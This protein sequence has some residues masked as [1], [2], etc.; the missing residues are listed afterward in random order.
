MNRENIESICQL[1][2][3]QESLILEKPS[4]IEPGRYC[5]Q[6]S[7][8]LVGKLDLTAI[9]DA[10]RNIVRRHQALR[11]ALALNRLEHP[12]QIVFKDVAL[13]VSH[14]DWRDVSAEALTQRLIDYL[15][16]D[17]EAGFNP[18]EAPLFRLS[19]IRVSD[20]EYRFVWTCNKL[21][22]DAV[23]AARVISEAFALYEASQ[24]GKQAVLPASGSYA[25]Y[26]AALNDRDQTAIEQFWRR[27]LDYSVA[28]GGL[29]FEGASNRPSGEQR[30]H[31]V[32]QVQLSEVETETVN[33]FLNRHEISVSALSRAAWA[34]T[35]SCYTNRDHAVFGAGVVALSEPGGDSM[36]AGPL[37]NILPF[38]TK[39]VPSAPLLTWLNEIQELGSRLQAHSEVSSRQL[40]EWHGVPPD[41]KLFD[42]G[43]FCDH[44]FLN[45]PRFAS[46]SFASVELWESAC[47][48]LAVS[49]S[50]T[51]LITL[52][53]TYETERFSDGRIESMLSA[54]R[55]AFQAIASEAPRLIA[56]VPLAPDEVLQRM[57]VE[58]NAG[59]LDYDKSILVNALF[60]AQ[61]QRLPMSLALDC[62]GNQ[63]SFQELNERANQLARYLAALGVGRED[64]VGIYIERSV[65]MVVG[66]L[67]IIKSGA[68]FVPLATS[69]PVERLAYMMESSRIAVLLTRE[70]L[71][72][73]LP[74]HWLQ[75]VCLD[76]DWP[77]IEQERDEDLRAA[78]EPDDVAY[79]MYTSGS[80]GRPKGVAVTHAGLLNLIHWHIR[81]FALASDDHATQIASIG[82]DASVW[83]IWP[84]LAAGATLHIVD[85]DLRA[86]PLDLM[87]WVVSSCVTVSF[88]PTPIAECILELDWPASTSLRILLVGGDRLRDYPRP[89]LP[90]RLV[91]NYGPTENTVVATSGVVLSDSHCSATPSIGRPISNTQVYLLDRHL[92]PVPMGMAGELC[93]AGESLAREYLGQP[94]LTAER[95]IPDPFGARPGARLYATGD[96]A[97]Y[98]SDGSIDFLGRRDHQVKIRGVRIELG[99]IEAVLASHPAVK[100]AVVVLREDAHEEKRLIAYIVP[101]GQPP[102]SSELQGY[103]YERLTDAMIPALFVMLNELPLTANGKLDRKALPAPDQRVERRIK[104]EAPKNEIEK[105]IVDVWKAVLKIDD[106]GIND[107]FFELG[108]DSILSIQIVAQANQS[109]LRITAKQLFEKKTIAE[110]AQVATLVAQA[111]RDQA[112]VSGAAPLT[113]IQEWFL[114]QGIAEVNRYN[115][116]VMLEVKEEID[117]KAMKR[118]MDAIMK[119]HDGLRLRFEKEE[120]QWRSRIEEEEKNE[121][122]VHIDLRET[123]KERQK[124]EIEAWANELQGSLRLKEGPILRAASFEL[125]EGRGRRLYMVAHHLGV[126]GVSWRILLEDLQRAYEQARRGEELELGAKTTSYKEWAKTLIEYGQSEGVRKEEVYWE[127]EVRRDEGGIKCDKEGGR[128]EVGSE[129]SVYVRMG[130]EETR[131]LLQDC[132][133][134]YRSQINELLLS[135]LA[136]SYE[137]WTGQEALKIEMEGHGREEVVEGVDVT[138]TVGWFT[139]VYPVVLESKRGE[140]AVETIKRVKEKL[141]SIPNKGIGYG[142]LRKRL[143][144]AGAPSSGAIAD[145]AFNYFGQFDQAVAGTSLFGL[146]QELCG[147]ACS[148]DAKR[149]HLIDITSLVAAGGLEINWIYSRNRF[150]RESIERFAR[151]YEEELLGIIERSKVDAISAFTASDF[152]LAQLSQTQVDEIAGGY[153]D[154]EDIYP[155]S[156]LQEGVLFHTLY[157]SGKGAY[158]EQLGCAMKGDINVEALKRAWQEEAQ[159]HAIWRTAFVWKGLGRPVQVVRRSV[160]LDWQEEDWRGLSNA[161]QRE[162]LREYFRK[163]RESGF[164]VDEAPLLKL[165]LIRLADDQYE[166]LWTHHHLLLDG[167]SASIVIKEVFTFYEA[168]SQGR[169]IDIP[170]ARPY[171][172]YIE[173]LGTRGSAE[174]DRYW[175]GELK[176]FETPTDL[177]IKREGLGKRDEGYR[178]QRIGLSVAATNKLRE[179]SQRRGLTVNTLLQGAWSVLMSRYS[180]EHD[181]VF[182][183]TVSGRPPELP[184]VQE[185]VGLFINTLPARVVV[186]P[187]QNLSDWLRDIQ[188]RQSEMRQYEYS[189]L[190]QVQKWSAV[191][192]G[193]PLF[194]SIVVFENY[195][196]EE[197]IDD[198]GGKLGIYELETYGQTNYGLNIV[199]GLG[200]RLW[201][202]ISYDG[203]RYE[204]DAIERILRQLE[205]L[206]E[207]IDE[208][209][210]QRVRD[211]RLLSEAEQKAIVGE[212]NKTQRAHSRRGLVPELI[213][214]QADATPGA[215]ALVSE[216]GTLSYAELNRRSNQLARYLK[217]QGVEPGT[218]VGVCV[219]RGFDMIVGLLG[220]LK[221]GGAY[222]PID[223]EYPA[224]RIEYILSDAGLG[225]LLSHGQ[226]TAR[227]P[228]NSAEVICL[229][230]AWDEIARQT[231][232]N[233]DPNPYE[234]SLAYVI[235][236]SGSTG[237]PK[238]AMLTHSALRNYCLAI[239]DALSLEAKDRVLQFASFSF[240]VIV[241]EV[242]PALIKG[243]SIVLHPG[244]LMASYKELIDIVDVQQVTLIELPTAYFHG[245]VEWLGVG[246]QSLLPSLRA[247]LV[248]G[249]RLNPDMVRLWKRRGVE[250]VHVYG[251]TEA[252]VT[253]CLHKLDWSER[254][255]PAEIPI[256]RPIANNRLYV[257]D[258]NMSPLPVGVT[259][260]LYIGGEGVGQ[261]YLN[262]A[263]LTASRFTPDPFDGEGSRLYKTGDLVRYSADGSIEFVGRR[264]KQVKVRGY[265]I[266]LGEIEAALTLSGFVTDAAVIVREDEPGDR[267]LVGYVVLRQSAAA[268]NGEL[269]DYLKSRLPGYMVP[270]SIVKLDRLPLT[271]NGK[272]DKNALPRPE[273]AGLVRPNGK[274]A[275]TALETEIAHI[276]EAVLKVSDIDVSENFFDLGG[277]S[278]LATQLVS[279]LTKKYQREIPLRLIFERPTVRELAEWMVGEESVKEQAGSA[280]ERVPRNAA[281]QL[282]LAQQRLW[283][284]DQLVPNNTFY[285]MPIALRLNGLL[286][287]R[288]LDQTLNEIIRRHE[289]LR[290]TF[291]T[292]G[293][294][295]V[296][297]I[298]PVGTFT[299]PLIDLAAIPEGSRELEAR[300]LA[301]EEAQR[302][303]DL[304]K[305]PLVRA[306]LLELSGQ[307]CIALFTM[308]HI[309]SDEWSMAILV[310]EVVALYTAILEG[311]PSPLHELPV[312]YADFAAWQRNR[313][314]GDFLDEQL[315]YWRQQLALSPAAL[316]LPLDHQRPSIQTYTG[317]SRSFLVPRETSTRLE[318]LARD[319]EA[320]LFMQLLTAFNL[321]LYR[322]TGQRDIVV[323]APTAG[324]DRAE[325]EEIIGFFINML[326]LR[327]DLS[328][329]P[330]YPELLSRVREVALGAYDHQELP[331]EK[332]VEELHPQRDMSRSPLFQVVFMLEREPQAGL[333]LPGLKIS[334]VERES[335]IAKVDLTLALTETPGGLAGSIA[336]NDRL[337]EGV[338]IERMAERLQNLLDGIASNPAH[339]LSELP[340]LSG[341]ELRQLVF[342]WNDTAKAYPSHAGFVERFDALARLSPD[343]I[344]VVG[345]DG[346]LTYGHLYQRANQLARRLRRLGTGPGALVGISLEAS[347]NMIVGMLGVLKAGAAY[348]GLDPGYPRHRLRYMIEDAGVRAVIAAQ[349]TAG[350]FTEEEIDL[351]L[352]DSGW[353]VIS[354][355]STDP[356][357]E[358]SFEESLAYAIYTSGTTGK[359]KGVLIEHR[360][361]LHYLDSIVD[362]LGLRPGAR[363]AVQQSLAV[364]APVTFIY[365]ALSSGSQ[366]HLLSHDEV[367]DGGAIGRYFS[368]NEIDYF[369]A[370]P[371]YITALQAAGQTPAVM[372]AELLLVGGEASVWESV[373]ELQAEVPWLRLVN[374]YGPTETTVGAATYEMS[375]GRIRDEKTVPIGRPLN[376]SALFIL[377]ADMNVVPE[378]VPGEIYV[379][380]SGLGRGYIGRADLTAE[381]FVPNSIAAKAGERLY[382]TGDI[383]KFLPG[384]NIEFI[385]RKDHQ[386]KIKG[387]RIELEEVEAA[388]AECEGVRNSVVMVKNEGGNPRLVACIVADRD[389][390][391]PISRVRRHLK[392]QLPDWMVPSSFKLLDT[393]PTTPQGKADR[394]AL[395]AVDDWQ[396][397]MLADY[398]AP[399][400][401]TEE[402]VARVWCEVLKLERVGIHDDFFALG[403]HSL[404]ATQVIS[405]L[406]QLFRAEIPLISLFESPTVAELSELIDKSSGEAEE[407]PLIVRA[408]RSAN[409]V[410]R[411]VLEEITT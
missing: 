103:L 37:T 227:L 97:C 306:S 258:E 315:S 385:G 70:S 149:F 138:R 50:S 21:A 268:V 3:T 360:Q 269:T 293:G 368:Q 248:G 250:T 77:L 365:A 226:I 263:G 202:Q 168:F 182:G 116:A 241:E 151:L 101:K 62:R 186:N 132:P 249:E 367:V 355:E 190:A 224:S 29:S 247:V 154:L 352:L 124:R 353:E 111:D 161:E 262:R 304:S 162:K 321:L 257:L 48:S 125:G 158:V 318:A 246:C 156:P 54:F 99:E 178:G 219:E 401:S 61:A 22:L 225:K 251:V 150:D 71:M 285:N 317:A 380:G 143:N 14:H 302:L 146:A 110:L 287:V 2:P 300:R 350:P 117:A 245:W 270:S 362:N 106:I 188:E 86:S 264:D 81:E 217:K 179:I 185:M 93:I 104:Y 157:E 56:D 230:L 137:R 127:E 376:N 256:G 45:L 327:T 363:Y 209:R 43:V 58:W 393:L 181:V 281:L 184:G 96:I 261:G 72:D 176:G 369:K 229:D 94:S 122:Y 169:P 273:Q 408:S 254:D 174:S 204:G 384:G 195:P 35:L 57:L 144:S 199:G 189:S 142:L 379:G 290:T 159:R 271:A 272:L 19:F 373:E 177:R 148:R 260:E 386:I 359:P 92:R 46:G 10:W 90:F 232:W 375:A 292:A 38:Q 134:V 388:I 338:T 328:G 67:G 244:K 20:D 347:M 346:R 119:H 324:R 335:S 147:E 406:R 198:H 391:D 4:S 91:N 155:L 26:T 283:F 253:S 354:T 356:I 343:S 75:I 49:V 274:H 403:G 27:A 337:F 95:F 34:L 333:E 231:D 63:I 135:A 23:S 83:E 336:Y 378:G 115:Q 53:L 170:K 216:N 228:E 266:E 207:S 233:V 41:E 175:S 8:R 211:L 108:G 139:S 222:L 153:T 390:I 40:R 407:A 371:S 395:S 409:R 238:A 87:D 60:E 78:I 64:K 400:N 344:A 133:R 255:L 212:F 275:A 284:L 223:P 180:G 280:I 392:E 331:F 305:G 141:R 389:A 329:D 12:V 18:I 399:R 160:A 112:P 282:S 234:E 196:V 194:D 366:I 206:F 109:G 214:G 357:E 323:G 187:E 351:L 289:S 191:P 44:G 402:A 294:D 345:E 85:D 121:V 76:A 404:M 243:A 308:H 410:K 42:S 15:L 200:K 140:E 312:Q 313:L 311:R 68:A 11:S 220:I 398:T 79:V 319:K 130:R 295:P 237:A 364:D 341:R 325:T 131:R 6:F 215:T 164:E 98:R 65:E 30:S 239:A 171:R 24:N 397:S 314:K 69:Q 242:F 394:L 236:T 126:D 47:C 296:Q 342:E 17:R 309:I 218:L 84:A 39:I 322:H 297:V 128:N 381:S 145:I 361:L 210:A 165:G 5:S 52:S 203:D 349:A 1:S 107:N 55:R 387:Y 288:A 114:E 405:R 172:D 358:I 82:F 213:R 259:G 334:P 299:L 307:E 372:P 277:H 120:G 370:A 197:S 51:P 201:I 66:M 382:R 88:I 320:T 193:T 31:A 276:W 59:R 252:A 240:D 286:N 310:R 73:Q 183:V 330:M 339:R 28:P 301:C 279:R 265:R 411:S 13:P 326:A 166:F 33:S 298:A 9:E 205:C 303:F 136:R 340:L 74:A 221:A 377:D 105:M 163:D 235:Y 118:S 332:L 80:T 123:E 89:T 25:N 278:L 192:P 208:N 129:E 167:W 374:H 348:L 152:P 102:T 396:F 36:P 316:N 267:R 113:P 32:K 173:W 7:C 16:E 100:D 291:E 383:G